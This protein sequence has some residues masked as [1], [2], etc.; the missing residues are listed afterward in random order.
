MKLF[1]YLFRSDVLR[2]SLS[3]LIVPGLAPACA[4]RQLFAANLD[5]SLKPYVDPDGYLIYAVLLESAKQSSFII[6]S[7]TDSWSGAPPDNV[8]TKGDRC[9]Q[10]VWGVVIKDLA[11]QYKHPRLLTRDIPVEVPYQLVPKQKLDD[12]F[13]PVEK[14]DTFHKRYPSA[15]GYYWFS[16]VGFDPQRGHAMV[17]M[18]YLCGVGCGVGEPHFFEKKNGKWGEVSVNA[19]VWRWVR[20]S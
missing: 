19:S 4:N 14:W 17:F 15:L 5:S 11:E 13:K 1:A 20:T 12:I 9:F 10:K 3:L 18:N 2:L 8:G 7:E 6:R 16:P